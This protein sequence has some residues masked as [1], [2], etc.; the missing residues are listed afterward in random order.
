MRHQLVQR[1]WRG[2]SSLSTH[3]PTL[4]NCRPH[5]THHATRFPLLSFVRQ[6]RAPRLG[7]S[8]GSGTL[9]QLPESRGTSLRPRPKAPLRGPV[10]FMAPAQGNALARGYGKT[11]V[12]LRVW[13]RKSGE[14]LNLLLPMPPYPSFPSVQLTENLGTGRWAGSYLNG[15]DATPLM[16]VS[17]FTA[18]SSHANLA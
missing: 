7:R 3:Q 6:T 5:S 15:D 18:A 11:T 10:K 8:P 2:Y 17:P 14:L 13:G 12:S 16:A 9:A 1:N 4:F